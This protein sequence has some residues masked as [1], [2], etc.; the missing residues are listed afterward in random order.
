MATASRHDAQNSEGTKLRESS[1]MVHEWRSSTSSVPLASALMATGASA[2][3]HSPASS[4][5]ISMSAA[6]PVR[7]VIST[8]TVS[9]SRLMKLP[10]IFI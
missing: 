6:P 1:R 5:P 3:N 7:V 10:C 2:S 8:A 4:V 9:P